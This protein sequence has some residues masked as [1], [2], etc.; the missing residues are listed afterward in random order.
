MKT[1]TSHTTPS[2]ITHHPSRP[3]HSLACSLA[4]QCWRSNLALSDRSLCCHLSIGHLTIIR[5]IG[6]WAHPD[7][8][9]G[10]AVVESA[11]ICFVY[12]RYVYIAITQSIQITNHPRK[13]ANVKSSETW[14]VISRSMPTQISWSLV[15]C[16][17]T[18]WGGKTDK[19]SFNQVC[20]I[21]APSISTSCLSITSIM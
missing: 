14:L 19:T 12:Y 18:N 6:W 20:V 21:C 15:P 9:G 8:C 11:R 16:D 13:K 5:M 17:I 4:L 1:S 7:D 3:H 10:D 2:L